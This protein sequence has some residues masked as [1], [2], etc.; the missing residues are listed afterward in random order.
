MTEERTSRNLA[1]H[2]R[3][4]LDRCC[5]YRGR[6]GSLL[7]WRCRRN[8]LRRIDRR[9]DSGTRVFAGRC[10]RLWRQFLGDRGPIRGWV[11]DG[12]RNECRLYLRSVLVDVGRRFLIRFRMKIGRR[13]ILFQ[14]SPARAVAL[15][16]RALRPS[17]VGCDVPIRGY[18]PRCTGGGARLQTTSPRKC[19]PS[20]LGAREVNYL[21]ASRSLPQKSML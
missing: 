6:R 17:R 1:W 15:G 2:G 5:C 18:G 16:A 19:D 13:R 20:V 11:D 9:F 3:L 7:A 12:R 14:A 8:G 10:R 4:R 21:H